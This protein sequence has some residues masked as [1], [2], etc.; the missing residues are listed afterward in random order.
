MTEGVWWYD[1]AACVDASYRIGDVNRPSASSFYTDEAEDR[2]N[3]SYDID[4]RSTIKYYDED[5][6]K[7]VLEGMIEV[8]EDCDIDCQK[9]GSGMTVVAMVNQAVLGLIGLNALFMFIGT[10][11]YRFRVCSVYCTLCMCMVQFIVLII[12]ATMLFSKYTLVMCSTSLTPTAPD[13]MWTMADDYFVHTYLWGA[14]II[15]MF[16]FVCFGMC[17]A[18]KAEDN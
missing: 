11:R 7:N 17:S 1:T 2:S 5:L 15:M 14:Q 13:M 18:Y 6:Y 16:V 3:W 12:S 9:M 10:W 4:Y 8:Y